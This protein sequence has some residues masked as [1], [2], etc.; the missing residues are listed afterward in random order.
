MKPS[1]WLRLDPVLRCRQ[2]LRSW[3][4]RDVMAL[5]VAE[6]GTVD[7]DKHQISTLLGLLKTVAT[8][9]NPVH[10]QD[11]PEETE[12]QLRELSWFDNGEFV[13]KPET[14]F[15]P[16]SGCLILEF[17]SEADVTAWALTLLELDPR[18]TWSELGNRWKRTTTLSRFAPPS[19]FPE[20]PLSAAAARSLRKR[21][22]QD[23]KLKLPLPDTGDILKRYWGLEAGDIVPHKDGDHVLEVKQ[24]RINLGSPPTI[25]FERKDLT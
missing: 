22:H 14:Q 7:L 3:N 15:Q 18:A 11:L 6:L 2:K 12:A 25:T 9:P 5:A 24:V 8:K 20:Y 21:Q 23:A 1:Q 16:G 10:Y 13:A 17:A 19:I 4:R